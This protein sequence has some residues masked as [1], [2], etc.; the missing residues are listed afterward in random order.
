MKFHFGKCLVRPAIPQGGTPLQ[1]ALRGANCERPETQPDAT[2][3]LR[4]SEQ[5][6]QAG[7][8]VGRKAFSFFHIFLL[9]LKEKYGRVE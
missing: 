3:P 5:M 6:R 1:N 4:F 9:A 8:F 2:R 7:Y